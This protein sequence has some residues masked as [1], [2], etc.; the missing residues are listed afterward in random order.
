[1]ISEL[2]KKYE[3]YMIEQRRYF[4]MYP[5]VSLKEENTSRMIKQQLDEMGVPY[6]ELPPNHGLV[7]TIQGKSGTK[8]IGVRADIDALPMQEESDIPYKSKC[9]GV[10][11]A[12]GHDAHIAM[13]LGV[14][15]VLNDYKEHLEGTVRLIFQSAEEIGKGYVEVVDYL[16]RTGGV[17]RL[18]GLHI[19]ST[20]PAGEILL[21]PGSVFAGGSGFTITVKGQEGHG[22]RPD[23]T[24]EPIKAACDMV[25]KMAA[26][27]SNMYDVLDHSVVSTGK[28][29]SGTLGNI[30][31]DTATILG[32][33]R[34]YKPG[35]DEAL[36]ECIR[37]IGAGVGMAYGVE[38][39]CNFSG[40][41]PP[42]YNQ[43][44]LIA[45]ARELV[46]GID[47]LVVSPQQ[48]PICAGD[49]F[50]CILRKYPGFYGVL[51]A[52]NKE[53]GCSWPQHN[54]KFNVDESSLRKGCEFM[55]AYVAD[56]LR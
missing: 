43:P 10:M 12:C 19:W 17:D 24:R 22:A 18:I 52:E 11:H 40:G 28:I 38:V 51:G 47:G 54:T 44:E 5:E 23:L 30:F 15:K 55:A 56:Y 48:D 26:I 46:D 3:D 16:D 25:L 45:H 41:I 49:N 8:T 35:G 34:Y 21:I 6:E 27:P 39:D 31:P 9:D 1:M 53:I 7:A 32:T 42:V 20:L 2:C 37:R 13:L 50:G 33:T 14:A 29:E 36:M 4:H